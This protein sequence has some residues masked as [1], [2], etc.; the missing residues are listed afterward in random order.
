MRGY[1][2][3]RL[4]EAPKGGFHVVALKRQLSSTS[5]HVAPTSCGLFE[6]F[7]ALP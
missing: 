3:N 1:D 5:A 7:D 2:I 4:G 6:V